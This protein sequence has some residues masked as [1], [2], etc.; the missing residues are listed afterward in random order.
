METNLT[1]NELKT[2]F[3]VGRKLEL[4]NSLMGPCAPQSRTVKA[5][6]SY[7]YDLEKADGRISRL[8][9][10]AKE[11]ITAVSPAGNGYTEVKVYLYETGELAAHYNLL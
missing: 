3:Y 4:V 8:D 6:R 2:L 9:L 7:G 1:R 11:R 10:L 5:Q